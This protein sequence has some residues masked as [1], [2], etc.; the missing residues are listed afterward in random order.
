MTALNVGVFGQSF[1]IALAS[2]PAWSVF[3]SEMAAA[4]YTVQLTTYA[5]DGS[6]A[7]KENAPAEFTDRWWWYPAGAN[8]TAKTGPQLA[9]A[10]ALIAAATNK[11]QIILWMQGPGDSAA[12]D[13]AEAARYRDAVLQIIWR[14]KLAS[15]NNNSQAAGLIP[16]LTDRI[17]RRLLTGSSAPDVQVIRE[18]Q[19]AVDAGSPSVHYLCDIWDLPL[20]GEDPL[21]RWPSNSH[22]TPVGNAMLGWRAAH[23]VL[24]HLGQPN[25]AGPAVSAIT[26]I[27]SQTFDVTFS[28]ASALT[29]QQPS[30]IS[31]LAVRDGST[32]YDATALSVSWTGATTARISASAAIPTGAKLLYPY[33]Y[34]N[35]IGSGVIR[36]S[37]GTVARSFAETLP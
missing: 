23:R 19:S 1:A 8:E 21:G 22:L 16:T 2:N 7:L 10:K 26:R 4:G 3:V 29:L 6:S 33:G 17:G 35:T 18:A 30:S 5:S 34:L 37:C 36:D 31:E 14:L 27:D 9:A 25:L 28:V 11:P 13:D 24:Q 12:V 20:L 15:A 32:V